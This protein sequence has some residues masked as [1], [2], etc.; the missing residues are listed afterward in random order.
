MGVADGVGGWCAYGIDPSSFSSQLM[1]ECKQII[2]QKERHIF[3]SSQKSIMGVNCS[4]DGTSDERSAQK[5]T[6]AKMSEAFGAPIKNTGMKR[7]RSSFHLDEKLLPDSE[8]DQRERGS[9]DEGS[10]ASQTPTVNISKLIQNMRIEPRA[11]IKQAFKTV[12][13]HGSST[14]CV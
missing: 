11:I 9:N 8:K 13:A 6:F 2:K 4:Q 3:M 1:T 14:A 10:P 7:I 5:A 12:T